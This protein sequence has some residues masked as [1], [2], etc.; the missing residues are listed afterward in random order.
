MRKSR[1]SQFLSWAGDSRTMPVPPSLRSPRT[2]L[3]PRGAGDT[4]PDDLLQSSGAALR[5][6]VPA[7]AVAGKLTWILY[8]VL[9]IP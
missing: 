1:C 3:A 6:L 2:A 5:S 4:H 9:R 8:P 7:A